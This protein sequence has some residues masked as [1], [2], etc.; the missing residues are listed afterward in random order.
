MTFLQ[1]TNELVL[2]SWNTSSIV[3]VSDVIVGNVTLG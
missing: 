3:G 2:G 1:A